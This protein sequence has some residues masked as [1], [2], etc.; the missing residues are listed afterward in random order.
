MSH[1]S[2]GDHTTVQYSFYKA[3]EAKTVV[4]ALGYEHVVG[5]GL[6]SFRFSLIGLVML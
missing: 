4:N 1:F 2:E 6:P 3:K 5:P